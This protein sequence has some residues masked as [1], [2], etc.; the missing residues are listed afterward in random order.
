MSDEQM[1][2]TTPVPPR[3]RGG[4]ALLVGASL[5]AVAGLAFA[6]GRFTAPAAATTLPVGGFPTGSFAPGGPGG[7]IVGGGLGG[8]IMLRGE[9]TAITS[10]SI[11]IKLANGSEVVVP[12]DG[13]TDYRTSTPGSQTDVTVGSTVAVQPGA[14]SRQPGASLTPGG[15]PAGLDFRPAEEITVVK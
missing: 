2:I 10:D 12:I 13:D 5:V 4:G 8:G 9:V 1:P 15:G 7:T 14:V 6:V 11:T 3:R